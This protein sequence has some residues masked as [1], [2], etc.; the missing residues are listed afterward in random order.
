MIAMLSS[1]ALCAR[2]NVP[3]PP[4]TDFKEEVL[5][6]M[7]KKIGFVATCIDLNDW[8]NVIDEVLREVEAEKED[9]IL[10]LDLSRSLPI[11]PDASA[12]DGS[13]SPPGAPS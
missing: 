9:P 7:I 12:S 5:V 11:L 3:P 8:R 6:Q 2:P 4:G 13:A 1:A 10:E